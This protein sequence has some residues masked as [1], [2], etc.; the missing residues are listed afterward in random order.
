MTGLPFALVLPLVALR[1]RGGEAQ[2][3]ELEHRRAA[4]QAIATR[5]QHR[6]QPFTAAGVTRVPDRALQRDA[7]TQ[8]RGA[9]PRERHEVG[10]QIHL[11]GVP[12][13][14]AA[15]MEIPPAV[16]VG[17]YVLARGRLAQIRRGAEEARRGQALDALDTEVDAVRLKLRLEV[18]ALDERRL[19]GDR[20]P[21]LL[22]R[23]HTHSDGC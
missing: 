6:E 5:I 9:R 13:D 4:L 20:G 18:D 3:H 11:L 7:G 15:L 12:D 10:R 8:E 1:G 17:L 2:E 23:Q 21:K 19:R 14:V 16:G 22:P